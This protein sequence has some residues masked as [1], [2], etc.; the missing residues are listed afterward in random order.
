MRPYVRWYEGYRLTGFPAGK[1][2][3]LP[4][5]D[6]TVVL[7]IGEPLDLARAAAPEQQP[8]RFQA[9]AGGL[10]TSPVTIAHD[11]NQHGIQLAL[12]P[13]GYGLILAAGL[14]YTCGVVFFLWE[15]LPF[16]NTIWHAFVFAASF[17]LYAALL[18]ELWGRAPSL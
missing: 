7:T 4:S 18:V 8:G 5:Q 9:L 17:V 13:A 6:L 10:T 14:L 15:R 11:G 1:H 12:T 2:L 3:G 16:H